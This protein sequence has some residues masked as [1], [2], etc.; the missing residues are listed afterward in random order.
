M[1]HLVLFAALLLCPLAVAADTAEGQARPYRIGMCPW[2]AWSPVHVAEM[3][4]IWKRLGIAVEVV[5]QHGEEEHTSAIEHHRVDLAVDMIGNLVGMHQSGLDVVI[6]GEFDWSH[7]GDKLLVR[8][9]GKLKAGDPIGIYHNDPAVLM[10]LD[11][12]LDKQGLK[13][14]EVILTQYDPKDLTG[15]FISGKLSCVLSYDPAALDVQHNGGE[16]LASTADFPG[17]MPEGLGGRSD[18][19]AAIPRADLV[20]ILQGWILAV[21]WMHDA[22]NWQEYMR[23]LNQRTFDEPQSEPEI[24]AMLANV[25]I[26]DRKTLAE[27]NG[28]TGVR[29]V[30][31]DMKRMLAANNLLKRDFAIAD[32]LDTTAL[33][34]ALQATEEPAKP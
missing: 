21:R 5:N 6:L 9:G 30:L 7:G 4:G 25:R 34:L 28:P 23:I 1:R 15:H 17:V 24:R 8:K 10:F 20:R 32:V 16:L 18:I 27:R 3:T 22:A 33:E 26:H 29:D 2:I 13:L 31:A 11:R 12:A 14:A 19:V